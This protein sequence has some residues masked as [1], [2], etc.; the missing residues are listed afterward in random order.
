MAYGGSR[1]NFLYHIVV[2]NVGFD[3]RSCT[4]PVIKAKEVFQSLLSCSSAPYRGIKETLSWA[5][6]AQVNGSVAVAKHF[7]IPPKRDRV[8]SMGGKWA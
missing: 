3:S 2:V 5:T 6:N 8:G 7:N 4:R 1:S